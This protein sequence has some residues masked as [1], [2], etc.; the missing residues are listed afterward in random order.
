M[1][2]L[3]GIC[4]LTNPETGTS[5]LPFLLHANVVWGD[6]PT[7]LKPRTPLRFR[8]DRY[9]LKVAREDF[10]LQHDQMAWKA[11]NELLSAHPRSILKGPALLLL[12]RISAK[13]TIQTKNRD[14]R[15]PLKLF[16]QAE[17]VPPS[18]W[19]KGEVRYRMGQYLIRQRF[20]VEGRGLL[21][22]VVSRFPEGPWVFRAK[23]QRAD[24]LREEG[25]L[26]E[27]EKILKEIGPQSPLSPKRL[28]R[29]NEETL[30]YD[31]AMGNLLMDEGRPG[32]AQDFY[33]K[34]LNLSSTYPY[35]HPGVLILLGR[36]AYSM[37]HNRRAARLFRTLLHLYPDDERTSDA[38]Y[39][40]A[41]ISGRMGPAS[42]ERARLRAV[43]A[44]NPG[45]SGSHLAQLQLIRMTFLSGKNSPAP[46]PE[47]RDRA[48]DRLA[49]LESGEKN[50]RIA[51]EAALLRIRLLDMAGKSEEAL[52]TLSR[53]EGDTDLSGSFGHRLLALEQRILLEKI[54]SLSHPLKASRI[55]AFYRSYR[56]RLPSLSSP[57]GGKLALLLARAQWKKGTPDKAF[58]NLNRAL[59]NMHDKES[60][61]EASF[62]RF[63]W[64]ESS[65]REKSALDWARMNLSDASL[66][67]GDRTLW[68]SRAFGLI[69]KNRKT[70]MERSL[71]EE[72]F[73]SGVPVEHAT[74]LKARLGLLD[75]A[76]G[77]EE[78]GEEALV[79]ALMVLRDRSG[80]KDLL[81][82]AL[83]HLG[84]LSWSRGELT[85]GE[86]YWKE[87]LECCPSDRRR[88]WVLYQMGNMALGRGDRTD[89]LDFF[90]RAEKAAGGKEIGKV[91]RLKIESMGLE[92]NGGK[93]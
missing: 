78:E 6:E 11:L 81:S 62:L 28:P 27:A 18:G 43:I 59:E 20:G 79:Q 40:M 58:A 22:Q 47:G 26:G 35:R 17:A 65:H 83:F 54:S 25:H 75:L 63:D 56:Y 31:Y 88:P 90:K 60:R 9:L 92:K 41:R 24:S 61:R 93:Q 70:S 42:H 48:I 67:A 16:R 49:Q 50:V 71:L 1:G 2:V 14:F 91:A 29:T 4:L 5:G 72:W 76:A 69:R 89:A 10:R 46:L 33:I 68:F 36:Y 30:R 38:E 34:A 32:E 66:P 23:L 57:G 39:Y 87:L 3:S 44:D 45:T 52:R 12:A 53:L 15:A 73:R 80:E 77:K 82:D 64:L 37:E 55:L 86:S 84:Q 19:D 21:D 74:R 8:S 51:G 85:R 7:N 13:E